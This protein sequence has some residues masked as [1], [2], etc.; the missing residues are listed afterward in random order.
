MNSLFQAS[1]T[2]AMRLGPAVSS[3]YHPFPGAGSQASADIVLILQTAA[4]FWCLLYHAISAR[5]LRP[6]GNRDLQ[7]V[8][9]EVEKLRFISFFRRSEGLEKGSSGPIT[10]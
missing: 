4:S 2:W 9:K 5:T 3:A 1:H 8:D 6:A 10:L 7:N